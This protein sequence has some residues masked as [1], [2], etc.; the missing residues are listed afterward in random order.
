MVE[1]VGTLASPT[2]P[3]VDAGAA[4]AR[5]RK[6]QWLLEQWHAARRRHEQTGERQDVARILEMCRRGV[7]TACLHD[8]ERARTAGEARTG[9]WALPFVSA[10]RTATGEGLLPDTPLPLAVQP[11]LAPLS[12]LDDRGLCFAL[13]VAPEALKPALAREFDRRFLPDSLRRLSCMGLVA[14]FVN[15]P[16]HATPP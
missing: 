8:V 12:K 10:C 9:G 7:R 1:V 5:H 4:Q 3:A 6:H 15:Y 16:L 11:P 14:A 2:F 13:G